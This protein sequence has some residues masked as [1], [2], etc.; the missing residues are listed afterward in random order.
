MRGWDAHNNLPKELRAQC[1]AVDQAQTA[2][3]K[4]LK[5]RGLLDETL[6][7]AVGE[8]GRTPKINGKGGRVDEWGRL[9][10]D[11]EGVRSR[12]IKFPR[13]HADGLFLNDVAANKQVVLQELFERIWVGN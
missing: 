12:M 4:D 13:C 10:H 2:L 5:R 6:V 7:V 9:S 8:M 11:F 3:I 1:N